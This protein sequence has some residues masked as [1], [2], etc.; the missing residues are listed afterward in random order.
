MLKNSHNRYWLP[1]LLLIGFII[2]FGKGCDTEDADQQPVG[3]E[4]SQVRTIHLRIDGDSNPAAKVVGIAVI[5]VGLDVH[6]NPAEPVIEP[7]PILTPSFPLSLPVT[8][9]VP[10]CASIRL[11]S[12]P[13]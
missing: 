5:L 7:A 10:P 1:G 4:G 9:F 11:M 12:R 6:G 3:P 8:L 13:H 2:L